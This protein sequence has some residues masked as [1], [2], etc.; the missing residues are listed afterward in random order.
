MD[1]PDHADLDGNAVD[2]VGHVGA[3]SLGAHDHQNAPSVVA[4]R[5]PDA[6]R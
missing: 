2:R 1:V 6:A 4:A 3:L 5:E